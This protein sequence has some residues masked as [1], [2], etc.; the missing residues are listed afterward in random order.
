MTNVAEELKTVLADALQLGARARAL[1]PDSPLAGA[2]PELDSQ[3]IIQLITAIE[4]S[5]GIVVADDEISGETFTTFGTL[6]EF[7]ASKTA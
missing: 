5:F 6:V 7:V 4:E 2:L 3:G 1:T